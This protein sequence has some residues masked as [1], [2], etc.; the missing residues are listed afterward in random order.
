MEQ[1]FEHTSIR[2]VYFT[3]AMPVVLSMAVTLIYNMVDTFFVAQTQNPALVA[4]VSQGAPV[5]TLLIAIGD[6]FGLGGSSVIS[7]LFGEKR[8][9]E[10]RNVSG[11]AFYAAFFWGIIVS[12]LMLIFKDQALHLLGASKATWKYA[13]EYYTV[14]A[15]GAAGSALA[16]VT[17]NVIGDLLMIY[18]LR[19]KSQKLT[20]SIKET[21]VS[22]DL[23]RQIYA[24]GIPA[25]I[26]NVMATLAMALTNRYLIDY[27]ADSVAAMGI[28]LKVSM[29][30]NM[31][32]IGFAFGAQPLI[33]YVYGAK[34]RRRFQ[35]ALRFDLL[36]VC[37]FALVMTAIM[38][39]LAPIIITWFMKDP[40]I[41]KEGAIMVRWLVISS[42]LAGFTLVFTTVFQSMGKA[43]PALLLSLARQG[44]I[45]TVAI[46]I[47]AHFFGYH[48]IIAA[49]A[50]A[51]LLTAILAI[52]LFARYKP[53]F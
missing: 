6:I 21:K 36:V 53:K 20:T 40:T 7:R 19:T 42:T 3:L 37:G 22:W 5:F 46:V 48:G 28:A 30:I 49:Q 50:V 18:Y 47:L 23:K 44:I 35:S 39:F 15:W 4:G 26:T 1:L 16:T 33:G 51:D 2:R 38:F 41:V 9:Q 25:S 32:F 17:S 13:D 29:I 52:A 31:I 11:Y 12:A 45:F 8:D 14:M 27:G 24:I 34:D 43:L 10:G